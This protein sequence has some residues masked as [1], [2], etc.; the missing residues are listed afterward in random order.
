MT[1][2]S[3]LGWDSFEKT[4]WIVIRLLWSEK[5]KARRCV[6]HRWSL[7][8]DIFPSAEATQL[9]AFEAGLH[10][11]SYQLLLALS[12]VPKIKISSS[13]DCLGTFVKDL[14]SWNLPWQGSICGNVLEWKWVILS[15]MQPA[16]IQ[17]TLCLLVVC[18]TRVRKECGVDLLDVSVKKYTLMTFWGD[19]F[20]LRQIKVLKL[21]D[22]DS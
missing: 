18:Q 8:S 15:A 12:Y 22:L 7:H 5:Q 19:L 16:A 14:W 10:W 13:S 9:I 20:I 17:V 3:I 1:H 11:P 21:L 4:Q 6:L 2:R